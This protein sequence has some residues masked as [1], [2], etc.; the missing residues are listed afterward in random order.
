MVS[1]DMVG[2]GSTFNIRN[3]RWAPQTTV[4]S[5]QAQASFVGQPLPYLKDL[6]TSGWSDHEQFE[7][8]GIPSAWLEW[9]EDPVYHTARDTASHVQPSRVRASGRLV[10]GWVLGMTDAEL[11]TLR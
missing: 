9:R 11:D 6:G 1:I 10:R 5:L 8:V 4:T 2:Y 7:Q 3:L